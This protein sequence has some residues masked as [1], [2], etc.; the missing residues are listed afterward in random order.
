[1][2]FEGKLYALEAGESVL[3]CLL[4]HGESVN[5]LCRSGACQSCMLKATAGVVPAAAQVGLKDAW[6]KQGY[7][8]ACVCRPQ[9]ELS[10]ERCAAF[11]TH[12]AKVTRV[13]QLGPNVLGV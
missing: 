2:L 7:F 12:S 1:M 3:D 9:E 11:G 10:V 13:K 6:K 4:R 8:L 5:S